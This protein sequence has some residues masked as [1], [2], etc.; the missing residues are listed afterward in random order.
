[1]IDFTT[2]VGIDRQH[3]AELR[4]TWP[5]WKRHRPEILQQPL[6][7]I[8]DGEVSDEQWNEE[9]TFLDHPD[10]RRIL[11]IQPGVS[12]REKMLTGLTVLPGREVLTAWYL[13]L[14]TD[15]VATG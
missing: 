5:T 11:W 8:C 12:Q 15:V 13:K 1:M 4:C 14:D 6:L 9:L 7:A 2:I 3:L 10:V